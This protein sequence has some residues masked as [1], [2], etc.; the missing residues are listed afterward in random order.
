MPPERDRVEMPGHAVTLEPREP[1]RQQA[2]GPVEFTE[3]VK[4]PV[5]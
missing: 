4:A 1:H 2:L 3:S 5:A